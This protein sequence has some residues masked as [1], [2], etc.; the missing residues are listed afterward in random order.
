MNRP[1]CTHVPVLCATIPQILRTA[2]RDK[3][4]PPH[5]SPPSIVNLCSLCGDLAVVM[6][7]SPDSRLAGRSPRCVPP[8]PQRYKIAIAVEAWMPKSR[9]D[10]SRQS[11]PPVSLRRCR[12]PSF[13]LELYCSPVH[14]SPVSRSASRPS[15]TLL[16]E[17]YPGHAGMVNPSSLPTPIFYRRRPRPRTITVRPGGYS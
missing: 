13:F 8:R 10:R 5:R 6:L 15:R 4:F 12:Q 14:L 11:G 3:Y 1:V 2:C 7:P 9:C 17:V 16:S